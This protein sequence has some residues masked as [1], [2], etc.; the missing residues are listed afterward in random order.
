MSVSGKTFDKLRLEIMEFR[1]RL[2]AIAR[3]D[4]EPDVVVRLGVQMVPR[5][6]VKKKDV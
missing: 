1:K 5:A 3:E 4:S 2:I 6:K